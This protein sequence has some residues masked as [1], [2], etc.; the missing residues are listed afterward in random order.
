MGLLTINQRPE[1]LTLEQ[2]IF[3]R[4]KDTKPIPELGWKRDASIDYIV[5]SK[6]EV[7]KETIGNSQVVSV[8]G[9]F[10]GDEAKGKT[11]AGI[12]ASIIMR[13]NSGENAG[14][15]VYIEGEKYVFHLMPSGIGNAAATQIIGSNCVMDPVSFY[16][17]ETKPL[18]DDSKTKNILDNLALG[19]TFI[20]T[21]YH[22]IMDALGKANSSTLKGMSPVHA[23]KALKKAFRL[24][25]LLN[26]EHDEERLRTKIK[27]GL[28]IY[29]GLLKEYDVSNKDLKT[30]LSSMNSPDNKR[31]PDH[32]LNFLEAKTE[33]EQI[34]YMIE[35]YKKTVLNNPFFKQKRKDVDKIIN[36]ALEKGYRILL[37][38]SQSCNLS[39]N[40]TS[41]YEGSTSA[42]TSALGLLASARIDVSK[43]NYTNIG[44]IK[45]VS[46]RVGNGSNPTGHVSQEFFS[47]KG[48]NSF[49]NLEGICENFEEI[50]GQFYNSIQENG[51]VKPNI[52]KD[53]NGSEYL[54]EEA[55]AISEARTHGEEG[56][57][58]KKPRVVGLID[59]VDLANNVKK[60]GS[61]ISISAMDR[62][63]DYEQIGLTV[64]YIYQNINSKN[65]IYSNGKEYTNGDIIRPGDSIPDEHVLKHCHRIIKVM[66]G[67]KDS[68]LAANKNENGLTE[69]PKQAKDYIAAV[70]EIAKCK[71]ISIGN[72]PKTNNMIYLKRTTN[73]K[74]A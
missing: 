40:H 58:T 9:N 8:T 12:D 5:S 60:Q 74:T 16:N 18:L 64:G 32:V 44:I 31:I 37:E 38:G 73:D 69:L 68:P 15:T 49:K 61:Y 23:D 57:T 24:D 66:E 48:I 33:K 7:M 41:Y 21:P 59:L 10:F 39:N 53:K 42:D 22:K 2:Q 14:H 43:Y 35:L 52:Y 70:E 50:K 36:D 20:V 62:G 29:N 30:R 3:S 28:K 45:F 4:I 26:L 1:N 19:N 34:N 65:P 55:M 46:S 27:S 25:D 63:D 47:S 17:K 11:V 13:V 6:E 56:A 51:I 71:V 72:G 54:I 67:W